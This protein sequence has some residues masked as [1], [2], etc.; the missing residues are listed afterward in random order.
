M[1]PPSYMRSVVDWNVVIRRIPVLD[2]SAYYL[3]EN[4]GYNI[5]TIILMI[6]PRMLIISN[7]LFV[8][9]T[10]TQIILKLLNC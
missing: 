10:H 5:W 1:G 9:L 2:G 6:A 3:S 7:P 8:Q 4:S